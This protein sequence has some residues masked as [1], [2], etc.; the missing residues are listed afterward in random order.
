METKFLSQSPKD[1]WFTIFNYIFLT[2]VLVVIL[3]PLIFILSS[4]LSSGYAVISGKVW[5]FPVD[6]TFEGYKAIVD[7]PHLLNSFKN[8]MIYTIVG[9]T[10]NVFLTILA[11]YPL[12]R[13]DFFGKNVVMFLFVFTMMF[14]GGLI[15]TYLLVKD[16][17][18]LDTMWAL[19]LPNALAV[20]NVI[21]T[22]T[23]FQTTL[24]TEMLEAAQID[25]CNDF[26][27][28]WRI[29]L[30]L[31][32][33]ILAVI[34]LFYAVGH[35]NRYFEALIYLREKDLFP[36]QLVLRELLILNVEEPQMMLGK[37]RADADA[38]RNLLKYSVIVFSSLPMLIMYPFV[39][40]HF[41]KG[42]MIGSLK[43]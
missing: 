25:G 18:L 10:I 42:M 33:P 40:R 13:R 38:L 21:I 28:V 43:G 1:Q 6:F 27:F 23:Y 34:T 16:L 26:K 30:P 20:W 41:V 24:P 7:H 39:Q 9:T 3:Y 12:S 37:D 4:S 15:P 17:S 32:G 8:T 5:L 36:L 22:R 31:S 35:Y 29:V 14:N 19:I 11:A 2:F